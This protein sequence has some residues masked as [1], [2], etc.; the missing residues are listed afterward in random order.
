MRFVVR[1][2]LAAV[3]IAFA[4]FPALAADKSFKESGLDE[5][6]I[7]L[8][9][10]IKADAG[11]VTKPAA[12]LRRDADAAFQKNDFRTGMLVLGQLVTVAPEDASSWLRLAR[13]VLQIRPRDDREKALLLDRASTAAYVAYQRASDRTV[14]ADSLSVLGRTLADRKQW[15]G[16]LNS[17]RLSLELRETAELRSQY[18]KLRAEHGF[19]LLD[20]T[21]DSDS[22]SPRACFQFSEELPGRRTDFSPFVAVAGIDRPAISS[23]EKQLCVEGLKHGER[24]SVTLR[25]GLPSVVKETLAKS[26]EFTIFVRDRKPFARFSGKAYVLPRTGQ[27]GIPVL[28]VNTNAVALSIFRIGDR[29][30]IDTLL[31]YDFQRNLSHYQAERLANE[32]G[33][34]VWSGELAVE[35]KLNTEVTTAFPLDQAVKDLGP[36]IYA[37]TAEPK[38]AVTNDY[39]QQATQWFIVSDLGLTAYTTHDGIDVFIHSLASAEPRGSVEVRLIARNNEVLATR[40]SDRNGFIHFEAGLARGE[41]GAAPAAIVASERS[42][43][44]FLSLK[45]PA[46]DLSDRGVAGRPIP[47]GLD[48]FVYTER[49][50]YRT[51]EAVAITALL[52]D[53]R[54]S[55]A[56]NVPLTLVVERPDG[57]EYRRALVADQGLG[58]HSL[59]VPIVASAS[60]GTW[61]VAAYTDPK[62]P[63]VGETTFMVE[64]YVPDRIEFNLASQAKEISRNAP[65]QLS[66][67]GHFLYGAPASKLELSGEVTIG[68]AKERA[69][70]PGYAFGLAD[71]EITAV[72]DELDDLTEHRCVGKGDISGQTFRGAREQPATRGA[73]HR[74]H[75]GIRRTGS[76]AQ[77]DPSG[78]TRCTDDRNQA[79]VFGPLACG[80]RQCRVRCCFGGAQWRHNGAARSSVRSAQDRNALPMVS[81][82]RSVGVRTGQ[83]HRA[84]RKRCARCDRRQAGAAVAAGEMGPLSSRNLE[85]RAEW[86]GYFGK[87]RCRFLR[88]VHRGHAG[89]AGGGARQA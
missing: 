74:Q 86:P 72:R 53:A 15:R 80:W 89:P 4:L 36:G 78:D 9:A 13:A 28:S 81:T 82:E 55:A 64:D 32:R 38:D 56:P 41:G 3:L 19:R 26:A 16:A 57:V 25:A 14:E 75:G 27:R 68:I 43:Y 54:G 60:T 87:L 66:V 77:A 44:A 31:G 70:F 34:K 47:V 49:G 69:G 17:L 58:G 12:V 35:P 76:R 21:V 62:R 71:D 11:T 42:D 84:C 65:A 85:R 61:R 22:I 33:A 39:G 5:A 50:V 37:M 63:P 7:K 59:S 6:A 51:G 30:L 1:A 67:D 79:D 88:R 2:G 40:Q 83:E 20:Y 73:S 48:A 10:Q 23:G 45:A 8:E 46:F 52:R 29:N 18:E 24:Y